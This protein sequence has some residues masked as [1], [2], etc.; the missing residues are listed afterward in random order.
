MLDLWKN[1]LKKFANDKII[2]KLKIIACHYT[3][4][5]RDAPH[6]ICNLKSNLPNEILVDFHNGSNYDYHFIIK[7]LA[8]DVEEQP[9]RLGGKH[10]KVQKQKMSFLIEK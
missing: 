7:E 10:R 5:Y 2:G 8:N 9:E 6:R 1:Y 4:K 3:G